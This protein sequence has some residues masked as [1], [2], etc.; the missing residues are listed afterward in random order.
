M[1]PR[2]SLIIYVLALTNMV[3]YLVFI[4]CGGWGLTALPVQLI[5]NFIFKPRRIHADEF[6]RQ[7]IAIMNKSEKLI[8]LGQK[9]QEAQERGRLKRSEIRIFKDFKE[10]TYRLESDWNILHQSF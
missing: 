9:L 2:I 5:K 6:A 10:A 4:I 8:E 7:K 1:K 3:G